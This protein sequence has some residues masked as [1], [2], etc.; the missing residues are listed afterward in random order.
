MLPKRR[1]NPKKWEKG[2]PWS[3]EIRPGA[4][5]RRREGPGRRE[6]AKPDPALRTSLRKKQRLLFHKSPSTPFYTN[7]GH[8]FCPLISLLNPS[9]LV[10]AARL[11][12]ATL[13]KAAPA[14]GAGRALGSPRPLFCCFAFLFKLQTTPKPPRK[15]HCAPAM[16]PPLSGGRVWPKSFDLRKFKDHSL[17][18]RIPRWR[19]SSPKLSRSKPAAVK[20]HQGEGMLLD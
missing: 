1:E 16:I 20:N 11:D 10:E 12:K 17:S 3:A 9:F 13:C 8:F 19:S 7:T 4:A 5:Q 15:L 14:L 18:K 2:K 6:A